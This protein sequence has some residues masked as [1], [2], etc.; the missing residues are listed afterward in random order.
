MKHWIVA[1]VMVVDDSFLVEY[2][3]MS[4]EDLQGYT[5]QCVGSLVIMMMIDLRMMTV[6]MMMG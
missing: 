4:A 5:V 6:K 3:D 2:L 1:A